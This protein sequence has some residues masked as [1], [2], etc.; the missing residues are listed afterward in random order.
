MIELIAINHRRLAP[1][2]DA[3]IAA[4]HPPLVF[5]PPGIGKTA[6]FQQSARRHDRLFRVV[7]LNQLGPGDVH[8]LRF[9]D[10]ATMTTRQFPPDFL[11]TREDPPTLLL[12]D[13]LCSAPE[14]TRKPALELFLSRRLGK[15]EL[16]PQ[17]T[18]G[19]ASNTG[20][21]GVLTYMLDA[22]SAE[23]FCHFRLKPDLQHW[24][25]D[26]AYPNQVDPR[27]I[28]YLKSHPADFVHDPG[29]DAGDATLVTPSPRSWTITSRLLAAAESAAPD[30]R[31][32]RETLELHRPMIAGMVGN[33]CADQFI[34]FAINLDV[35]CSVF[36]ILQTPREQRPALMPTTSGG[37]L[38]LAAAVPATVDPQNIISTA[39]EAILLSALIAETEV[40]ASEG[41]FI[42]RDV[43]A[44]GIHSTLNRVQRNH[45]S[46]ILS[47][48][49][50]DPSLDSA[51]ALVGHKAPG[52]DH[53]DDALDFLTEAATTV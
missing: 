3:C 53:D 26:Y 17:H 10:T 48:L 20:D 15:Y 52:N 43:A 7:H 31:N 5:G 38:R 35:E 12:F 1:L 45:D 25:Q 22:A 8:G 32:A 18:M 4:G 27:I 9:P 41:A 36:D 13:E 6:L 23:R 50:A 39:R 29:D 37:M 24:I 14:L 44:W 34:T 40:D 11:P 46:G 21:D 16:A 28:A 33:A 30:D 51:L 2:V 49:L 19:A 47:R 42:S